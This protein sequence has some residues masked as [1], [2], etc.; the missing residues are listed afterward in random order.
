MKPRDTRHPLA[1]T[2][3]GRRDPQTRLR[4]IIEASQ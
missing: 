1:R 3:A 4:R 2:R